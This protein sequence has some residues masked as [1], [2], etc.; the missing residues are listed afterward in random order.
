MK[1]ADTHCIK[2]RQLRTGVFKKSFPERP[3]YILYRPDREPAHVDHELDG[4]QA[5]AA[6][7]HDLID[8]DIPDV[9]AVQQRGDRE[10]HTTDR[11]FGCIPDFEPDLRVR[12]TKR[13]A[14]AW[15]KI[16]LQ[17]CKRWQVR[18]RA[19]RLPRHNMLPLPLVARVYGSANVAERRPDLWF[20]ACHG[21]HP[22]WK[23]SN[24]N[25]TPVSVFQ[26]A[27]TAA[28]LALEVT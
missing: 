19:Q 2:H 3:A 12:A 14:A 10:A 28:K 1:L 20:G 25:T 17:C 24:D 6:P 11:A 18:K 26:P 8:M 27:A 15:R 23:A 22:K 4:C 21:E 13:C 9:G 7:A 16:P 5:V